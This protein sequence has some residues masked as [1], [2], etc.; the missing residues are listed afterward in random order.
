[1]LLHNIYLIQPVHSCRKYEA[2]RKF[3]QTRV[4]TDVKT[5]K[6]I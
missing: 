6:A 1:M 2:E 5:L 3:W 4:Q